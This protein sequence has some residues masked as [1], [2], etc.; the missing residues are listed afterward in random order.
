MSRF[1]ELLSMNPRQDNLSSRLEELLSLVDDALTDQQRKKSLDHTIDEQ[2]GACFE[3]INIKRE[4]AVIYS[5]WKSVSKGYSFQFKN[6][7]FYRI[8]YTVS[9][10]A[11][12]EDSE[13]KYTS[14]AGTVY[15]LAPKELCQVSCT[16][17][18]PWKH[19]Y[20]HFTGKNAEKIHKEIFKNKNLIQVS[21]PTKI[22]ALFENISDECIEQPEEF[23]TIC[24]TYLKILLLKLSSQNLENHEHICSSKASYL[25]CKNYIEQNFNS[26]LSISQVAEKCC[27]NSVYLC[28]LFRKHAKTSPMAYI[29]KL[30]MQKATLLL[31]HTDFSIKKISFILH[32]ANQYYFSKVFKKTFGVSPTVYRQNH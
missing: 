17:D 1:K 31:I 22:Q 28:R 5:G 8:V 21:D 19:Y 27:V 7:P 9:G 16:S 26:I 20:I 30:K 14:T 10:S 18:S 2:G 12:I 15:G 3:S 23:Q 29:N 6:Y 11:L 32:Y 13:D 4:F 25:R 24:D